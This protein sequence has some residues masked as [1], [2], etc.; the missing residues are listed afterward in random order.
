MAKIT[1]MDLVKSM[2]GKI[3]QHSDTSFAKRG[4]TIYTQ[5]R[6]NP[7]DLD[8]KPYSTAELGRQTKFAT[9]RANVKALTSAEIDANKAAFEKQ[10][11]YSSLQGYMFAQEYAKL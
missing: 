2:T 9:A 7:R 6:C 4:D 11:K 1:P 3:C 5:K 8:K 10:K